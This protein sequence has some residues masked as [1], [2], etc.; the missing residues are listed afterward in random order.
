MADNDKKETVVFSGDAGALSDAHIHELQTKYGLQLKVRSSAESVAKALGK[1]GEAAI[2]YFDRVNP[3]YERVFDR[4][5]PADEASKVINP[6]DL[7]HHI[8]GVAEK[9]L[10]GRG[11]LPGGG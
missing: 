7:E 8:R 9:V 2:Q 5:G 11:K 3:G 6:V 10:A 4:T 1:V